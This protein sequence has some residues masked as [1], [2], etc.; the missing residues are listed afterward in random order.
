MPPDDVRTSKF[1]SLI[2]RHKPERVG[3]ALD[4]EGWVEIDVLLAALT[5][6]G[7][8]LAR[9]VLKRVVAENDK[10]RF[11]ISA[12]G[13]RIRAVQGHSRSVDLGLAPVQPPPAL[14]HGTVARFVDAIR[15]EGLKPRGRQYVH[16]SQDWAT[17]RAVGARRGAA[18]VLTV[19]AGAMGE[20]GH[21]F[22][23]AGNGVWLCAAVPAR[24]IEFP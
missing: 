17:A 2:L 24:Y 12:D 15:R 16:L 11:A 22:F 4:A 14:Y 3:L 6:H 23:R 5:N 20:E 10:K 7:R 1:L 8:P 21:S 9:A 18:V 19:R 13:A